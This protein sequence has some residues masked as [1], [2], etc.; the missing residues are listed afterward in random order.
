MKQQDIDREDHGTAAGAQGL[1]PASHSLAFRVTPLLLLISGLGIAYGLGLHKYV[2]LDWLVDQRQVLHDFVSAY[3]LRA[4]ALFFVVY[5]AVVALS[6]PAASVLTIFAGFLFGW[7][8]GGL[9]VVVAAT[10]GSCLLFAAAHTAFGDI[11]RQRAGPFLGRFA[12][13][14]SKNAFS[15]LL[16]LRLAPIFP[17]FVVNIAPAF[18]SVSL[19]TFAAA[20]LVGIIPGTFVYAWLGRGCERII[21]D[22]ATRDKPLMLS[23][24]LVPEMTFSLMALA[25]IAALPLIVQFVREK[26]R[27][28][29]H[30]GR[31]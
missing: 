15:Y 12:E 9:L 1:P 10:V 7:L 2:S 13:G 28:A 18:F 11:L 3:P 29:A 8:A 27:S 25:I 30:G 24:F 16:V 19:R 5:I 20:T 26:K 17:F 23:D 22:A 6:I 31:N 21:E 4:A 14:F